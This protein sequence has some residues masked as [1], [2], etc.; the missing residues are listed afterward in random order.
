MLGVINLY[1]II[2]QMASVM[3][4]VLKQVKPMSEHCACRNCD[5]MFATLGKLCS[6]CGYF[7]RYPVMK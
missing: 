2:K 5:N 3:L 4:V 7:N 6:V 1:Q